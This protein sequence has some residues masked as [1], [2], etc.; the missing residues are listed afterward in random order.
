MTSRS[1]MV[2]TTSSMLS[3]RR[4]SPFTSGGHGETG[5]ISVD[6]TDGRSSMTG[7]LNRDA[8]AGCPPDALG[9][10]VEVNTNATPSEPTVE[11]RRLN[12][13][14]VAHIVVF[15]PALPQQLI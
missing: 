14:W 5:W 15:V 6:P 9:L 3:T 12:C 11:L 13:G 1:S 8:R 10:P 2:E 7:R 4:A